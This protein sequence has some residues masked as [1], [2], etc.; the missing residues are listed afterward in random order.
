[1]KAILGGC[2]GRGGRGVS[3]FGIFDLWNISERYEKKWTV[4]ERGWVVCQ[5]L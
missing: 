3:C 5:Y 4:S 2:Q 1:M